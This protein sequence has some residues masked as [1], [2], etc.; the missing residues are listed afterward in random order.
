MAFTSNIVSLEELECAVM[1]SYPGI[2][3]QLST[4]F[5]KHDIAGDGVL[6]YSVVEPLLRHFLVTCGLGDYMD[7]ITDSDGMFSP[8]FST[9]NPL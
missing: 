4:T 3:Q 9:A 8:C 2:D 6:P 5:N 1:K 7:D